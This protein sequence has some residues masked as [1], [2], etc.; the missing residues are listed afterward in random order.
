MNRNVI[1]NTWALFLIQLKSAIFLLPG[2]LLLLL[3][4]LFFGWGIL[5]AAEDFL[6]GRDLNRIP[7]A[8]VLPQDDAY[9]GLAFSYVERMD[10]IRDTCRFVRADETEALR[11]L[12]SGEVYAAVLIPDSF[13]EHILNGTNS[14]ATLLLPR[15]GSLE[16]ILFAT[17]ASSGVSTLGTAQA[18]IYALEDT[19][20]AWE[21][22]EDIPKAGEALNRLYLS[23]A[24][25]RDRI[26]R[27]ERIS[28]T[29]SLPLTG[30]YICSALVLFLLLSGMGC[31]RYYHAESPGLQLLLSRQRISCTLLLFLKLLAVTL[32]YTLLLFPPLLA[33]ELVSLSSLGGFLLLVCSTQAFLLFLA[34]FCQAGSFVLVS[35]L[36]SVTILFLS[37]A[38]IPE[39]FLPQSI[40]AVGEY[41]PSAFYLKLCREIYTGGFSLRAV[42]GNLLLSGAFLLLS[43]LPSR[44]EAGARPWQPIRSDERS[45][46]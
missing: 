5:T 41:L 18:G 14:P 25:N 20:I 8:L 26:F 27:T 17:L 23:Y 33:G 36:L 13:V 22:W 16:S 37:G 19:L 28:A 34:S 40:R 42:L 44:R 35:G 46:L 24:L 11:L 9:A 30:Y 3:C 1:K 10:S 45:L 4:C 38:F 12:S 39:V 31:Y 29:D 6:G 43:A 15:E 32:L 2:L 7:V 21:K